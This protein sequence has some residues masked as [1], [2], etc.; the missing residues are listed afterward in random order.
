MAHKIKKQWVTE[1]GLN[2]Y[3]LYVNNS[4][5]CGYVAVNKE[6]PYYKNDYNKHYNIDV[7][8]GLT[9]SDTIEGI[10]EPW[11][12]GFDAAHASDNPAY[13]GT[14]KDVDYMTEECE[15]LAKQLKDI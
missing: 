10:D 1:A 8:E 13:G 5:H 14:F 12:F 2:A 11:L 9:F 3:I 4:H 6:H 7:H 15:Q